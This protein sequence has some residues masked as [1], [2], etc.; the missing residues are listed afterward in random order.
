M[1]REC[2]LSLFIYF[3]S[4]AK[5]SIA[6]RVTIAERASCLMARRAMRYD[7]EFV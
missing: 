3:D 5:F 4:V 2:I 7:L 1:R 6:T